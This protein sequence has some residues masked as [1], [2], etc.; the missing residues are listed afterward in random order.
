MS[1]AWI[2]ASL[3]AHVPLGW[4]NPEEF[5]WQVTGYGYQWWTGFFEHDGER[6]DAFAARGHGEQVLM[7]IPELE[8]VVAVFSHAFEARDDEVNQVFRLIN[9][10]VI[11]AV[12]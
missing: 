11:E 6:F 3:H 1:E 5:D 12:L 8:L 10:Y 7:V 9:E 4:T 2:D